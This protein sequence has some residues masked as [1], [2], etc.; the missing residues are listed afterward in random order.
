MQD[1]TK[2]QLIEGPMAMI[3]KGE[4]PLK[5]KETI[6]QNGISKLVHLSFNESGADIYWA[7]FV[8]QKVVVVGQG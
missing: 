5:R 3:H 2:F 8:Y 4:K 6:L 7:L 1:N